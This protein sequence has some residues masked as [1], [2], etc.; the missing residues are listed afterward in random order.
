MIFQNFEIRQ[1]RDFPS[2]V[3]IE[4]FPKF[5]FQR[6]P[7]VLISRLRKKKKSKLHGKKVF[8]SNFRGIIPRYE[9]Y[10]RTHILR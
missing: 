2:R 5:V 8:F 4:I 3:N 10:S 1:K 6:V 7:R 9:S